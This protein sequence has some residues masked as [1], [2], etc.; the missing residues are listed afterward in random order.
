MHNVY[1]PPCE[2]SPERSQ[3]IPALCRK[4][5]NYPNEEFIIWGS[6]MQKRAFIYVDDVINGI[7]QTLK[8]GMNKGVIQIGPS[9]STSITSIAKK[10]VSLSIKINIKY[11]LTK[12]EG[13]KDRTA[14]WSKA[15]H[16]INW[17][18]KI[19]IEEGLKKTYNWIQ[20][21]IQLS[22]L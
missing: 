15:K 8:K 12:P 22:E 11:D 18:P 10:I 21:Y 17:E 19:S 3:V 2:I 9:E 1:G 13:D 4:A 7:I 14:D 16:L 6:G 5:I 20:N